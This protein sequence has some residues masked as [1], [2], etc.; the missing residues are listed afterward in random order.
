MRGR[1]AIRWQRL[2]KVENF[3]LRW[4]R[5]FEK[6]SARV[7]GFSE[8]VVSL[9]STRLLDWTDHLILPSSAETRGFLRD[10]GFS[11]RSDTESAVYEHPGV[12]LPDV[13]LAPRRADV[14]RGLAIRVEDLSHFLQVNQMDSQI[15]GAPFSPLRRCPLF[16]DRG[17]SLLAVERRGARAYEVTAAPKGHRDRYVD[18]IE[19]WRG[20]PRFLE[21]EDLAFAAVETAARRL[22]ARLGPDLAAHVVCRCERDYWLSRNRA[23]RIQKMRQDVLGLGWANHDHHT[24]RSSR[25]RFAG[26]VALFEQLDFEKRERFYAGKEAGWGAQVMENRRAG[27]VLFLDVDLTPEELTVDFAA[28]GL[29]ESH[30]FGTVGLW[31]ALHGDSILKAGM[32]H[33]AARFLFDRL[34]EALAPLGI[35]FMG[36]FSDF[37]H[38]KQSFSGGET[39]AVHP[40]RVRSLADTHRID[41]SRAE[42][43]LTR[44]AI[45]SHLENIQ[46]REGYKGFNKKNVSAIIRETDPRRKVGIRYLGEDQG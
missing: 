15:E 14:H 33:L 30:S 28:H 32:H 8:K 42:T 20:I 37:V 9:T 11:R 3:F 25:T 43:F 29:A 35:D 6:E 36:P 34:P 24:F 27:L 22:A 16:T 18:A 45:G 5:K 40:A 21:D 1:Q 12:S 23:A 4:V 31:C 19:T 46:R 2:P 26:L 41:R 10:L 7:R 38:L 39:W 13:V 44:G 17:V